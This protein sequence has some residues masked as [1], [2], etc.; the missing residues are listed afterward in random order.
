MK[1]R[2]DK[3]GWYH[4]ER[5]DGLIIPLE[6]VCRSTGL[7]LCFTGESLEHFENSGDFK[8]WVGP[9]RNDD[10]PSMKIR[11]PLQLFA[12]NMEIKLRENDHKAG[13][14]HMNY[15]DLQRRIGEELEEL[16][17]A[18]FWGDGGVISEAADVANFCMMIADNWRAQ[19]Q[20]NMR[21]RFP[22]QGGRD[23]EGDEAR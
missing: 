2:P 18:L 16:W 1:M 11:K 17:K 22:V 7:R 4:W 23:D 13:W 21:N 8:R 12:E 6:L 10:F 9:V 3:S 15:R 20:D 14:R 19:R 5:V